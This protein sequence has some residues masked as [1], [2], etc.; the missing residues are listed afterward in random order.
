[1]ENISNWDIHLFFMSPTGGRHQISLAQVLQNGY[2]KDI[3]G[4]K[5]Y[6]VETKIETEK[7]IIDFLT[8]SANL[9]S[10]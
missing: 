1:M 2:P 7:I 6:F 3:D 10:S 4:R 5:F 9:S 8:R